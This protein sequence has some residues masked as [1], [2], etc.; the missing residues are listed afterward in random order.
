MLVGIWLTSLALAA[1][2]V[3]VM[4]FLVLVRVI[5]TW[6]EK[7]REARRAALLA[8][9][10]AWFDGKVEDAAIEAEMA[11]HSKTA[12]T[13]VIEIFEL[14][15][16]A[17][18]IRLAELA[19]RC[20]LADRLRHQLASRKPAERLQAAESLIWFP[21]DE[22]EAALRMA[23]KD[24]R[25]DV[26]LA[27]AA[28]LA[29][30]G[31]AVP[32]SQILGMGSAGTKGSSRRLEATL[33]KLADR[34]ATDLS[35]I[36]ADGNLPDRVRAAAIDAIA[37]TGAFE[38]LRPIAALAADRSG[39]VRAA[40]AHALGDFAHPLGADAVT[41]L[42]DDPD[43]KVRAEAAEAAGRIG[44]IDLADRLSD[45][46][47]DEVWWVRFRAGGAL[48][49]LGETGVEKLRLQS[50]STL[51]TNRRTAALILAERGLA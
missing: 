29:E 33:T 35:R 46:L 20:G 37:R 19:T 8:T 6:G 43:W 14:M 3:A 38:F 34:Q 5:A 50:I 21:S 17:D 36:A 2:S 40:V 48:V 27:A 18:Q 39:T 47:G 23:L 9:V 11:R 12:V 42:L 32:V 25:E 45:L 24:R 44:L 30:L 41:R 13:L 4:A 26:R 51:D 1:L 22:T 31:A 15:R 28:S 10:F 7:R 16:G 49:S